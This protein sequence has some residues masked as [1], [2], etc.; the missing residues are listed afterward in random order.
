MKYIIGNWKMN[1][2]PDE[3][4]K[5]IE[6]LDIKLKEKKRSQKESLKEKKIVLCVPYI[7]IFYANLMAQNTDIL[8]GAQNMHYEDFGEYTGEIS[9]NNA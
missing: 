1:I 8:I 4:L 5:Y 7:D 9:R 2:L 6:V 3:A